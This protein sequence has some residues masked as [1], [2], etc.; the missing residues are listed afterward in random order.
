MTASNQGTILTR[1]ALVLSD[2][3]PLLRHAIETC[4][5]RNLPVLFACSPATTAECE[6]LVQERLAVKC[7][8]KREQDDLL[9]RISLLISLHCRQVF[10]PSVARGIRCVNFHPGL[11]PHNR[12]WFPHIFSMINGK[13]AGITI[14]EMDEQID[15]GPIIHQERIQIRANEVSLDVYHRIIE[16]EKALFDEWIERLISGQYRTL[17][18]PE[19]GNYNSRKDFENLKEIPLDKVCTVREVLDYLRAMTFPGYKNAWFHDQ[20]TGKRW[21]VSIKLEEE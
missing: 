20:T 14:H 21:Y 12:G 19:E 8:V 2:N 1:Q 9:Y 18:P 17:P 7:D 3:Y 4:R 15:H 10:P 16:R 5:Q 6:S 13:P 11:N